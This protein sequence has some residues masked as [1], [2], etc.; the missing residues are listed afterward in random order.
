MLSGKTEYKSIILNITV[1]L[2]TIISFNSNKFQHNSIVFWTFGF[3]LFSMRNLTTHG[4][5]Y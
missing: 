1:L 4:V 5:K 2:T 3:R